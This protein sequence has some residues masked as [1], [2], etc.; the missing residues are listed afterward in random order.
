MDSSRKG[1]YAVIAAA[2]SQ[3]T[4]FLNALGAL[5]IVGLMAAV[6]ADVIGRY[7]FNAPLQ[8]IPELAPLCIVAI[9]FLQVANCQ[10]TGQMIR[11][12]SL[13]I[14]LHQ[15]KPRLAIALD[16]VYHLTGALL[17]LAI[18]WAVFPSAVDA[19][20][21]G[22][23]VGV[24]GLFTLPTWPTKAA[25]VFGCVICF[26]QLTLDFVRRIST[27]LRGVAACQ[28]RSIVGAREL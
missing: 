24:Q 17:F 3:L 11:S 25:V 14:K 6:N 7:V 13:L 19:W 26:I 10:R 1:P 8:G 21:S 22:D 4:I 9:L 27:V 28:K 15:A 2:F 12:D 5:L 20:Q 18:A 16:A 23:F